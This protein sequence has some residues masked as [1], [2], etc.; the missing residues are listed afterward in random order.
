MVKIRCSDKL[1]NHIKKRVHTSD[2]F[3]VSQSGNPWTQHGFRTAWSRI[4]KEFI[5]RYS[6]NLPRPH[7]LRKVTARNLIKSDAT[8]PQASAILGIDTQTFEKFYF[9]KET[10]ADIAIDKLDS[11]RAEDKKLIAR[12][13]RW[14]AEKLLE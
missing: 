13:K 3:L 1:L 6:I 2:Y 11:K 12:L 5:A 9:Q 14:A 8:V 4:R 7:D 10:I